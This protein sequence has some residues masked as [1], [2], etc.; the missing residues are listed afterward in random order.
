MSKQTDKAVM[1]LAEYLHMSPT[2]PQT[3]VDLLKE[4][5]VELQYQNKTLRDEVA[6]WHHVASQTTTALTMLK[7]MLQ[8]YA[9]NNPIWEFDGK[10]QDPYGVH[11]T[12]KLLK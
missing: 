10:P 5:I 4:F 7:P 1:E 2:T 12:L 6:G 3:A 11:E 8:E 9:R